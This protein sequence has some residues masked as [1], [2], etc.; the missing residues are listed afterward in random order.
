MSGGRFNYYDSSLMTELF[1]CSWSS[2]N[3]RLLRENPYED[4]EISELMYDLLQLTH[5]LDWYLSCDT[6]EPTYLEAKRKFKE[7]WFGKGGRK[8]VLTELIN[9]VFEEAKKDCLKMIGVSM[10]ADN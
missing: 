7:K 3:K 4:Q 5:D 8:K 9:Q 6:S 2:E 10:D 1:P